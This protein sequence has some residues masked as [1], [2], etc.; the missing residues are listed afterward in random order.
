[1]L[2]YDLH[3]TAE[4]NLGVCPLCTALT[5]SCAQAIALVCVTEDRAGRTMR[6]VSIRE[7]M[8]N[9]ADKLEALAANLRAIPDNV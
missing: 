9:E 4:T 1:M 3:G 5:F 7:H 6:A 8:A 2:F